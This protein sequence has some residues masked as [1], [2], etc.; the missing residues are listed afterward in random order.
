MRNA[1]GTLTEGRVRLV[2]V[3]DL[4]ALRSVNWAE[5]VLLMRA[6]EEGLDTRYVTC[7]WAAESTSAGDEGRSPFAR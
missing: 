7:A 6:A 3:T 5:P 2:L 1:F 4:P